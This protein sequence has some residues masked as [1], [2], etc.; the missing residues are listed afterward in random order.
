MSVRVKTERFSG[1]SGRLYTEVAKMETDRYHGHMDDSDARVA[2]LA[3][4]LFHEHGIGATGVDALSKAAG[5]SKRTLYER[6]GS[7]DGLICAAFDALDQPVF[8][9]IIGDAEQLSSD[10][11][12]Q[13]RLLFVT[14]EGE[15]RQPDFRGCP[16]MNA[17]TELADPNHPAHEVIRRHK[18][19]LRRWI[20]DRA[21]EAGAANPDLLSRQLMIIIDGA[22]SQ[23]L[24]ER[25]SKPARDARA[26]ANALI[27][28]A[29][30]TP[31][32]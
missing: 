32:S 9:R 19:R 23:A 12:E 14:L 25:S 30:A 20:R 16:F 29:L 31:A 22:Q 21:R 13:L 2:G 5:I 6:F 7:K 8:E 27:D 10:P 3:A 15:T 28:A 4:H 11:R 17:S 26:I 18:H 1:A 24:L